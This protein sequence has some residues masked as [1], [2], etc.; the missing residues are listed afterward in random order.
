MY[1]DY[2]ILLPCYL[3]ATGNEQLCFQLIH[4][5]GS[6]I[7]STVCFLQS[8]HMLSNIH[9]RPRFQRGRLLKSC[10]NSDTSKNSPFYRASWVSHVLQEGHCSMFVMFLLCSAVRYAYNSTCCTTKCKTRE[11]GATYG[12]VMSTIST[13]ND[14]SSVN[15][16]RQSPQTNIF[17]YGETRVFR[18]GVWV[19]VKMLFGAIISN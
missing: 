2:H 16:C 7:V 11:Q 6:Y 19:K 1:H 8:P 9:S 13:Y 12:E 17:F 18:Q 5:G 4:W 10:H 3:Y 14:T 15:F